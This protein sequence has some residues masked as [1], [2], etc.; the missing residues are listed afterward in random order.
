MLTS[1]FIVPEN[2]SESGSIHRKK[3][4]ALPVKQ[5]I[6]INGYQQYLINREYNYRE[7]H[8]SKVHMLN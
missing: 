5:F 2:K 1:I 6:N 8:M 4:G 7:F 3:I